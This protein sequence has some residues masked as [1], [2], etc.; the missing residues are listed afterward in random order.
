MAAR[1]PTLIVPEGSETIRLEF[2]SGQTLRVRMPD[3]D[4]VRIAVEN[5]KAAKIVEHFGRASVKERGP[6][7]GLELVK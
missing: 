5:V 2:P 7:L 6:V 4:H 3:E 1:I